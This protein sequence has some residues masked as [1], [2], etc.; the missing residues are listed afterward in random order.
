[1]RWP[2]RPLSSFQC[3]RAEARR[4]GSHIRSALTRQRLKPGQ[5][6]Q[7]VVPRCSVTAENVRLRGDRR[8]RV[9]TA[10]GH[11]HP[12]P[13]LGPWQ[14]RAASGAERPNMPGARDR[15][16]HHPIGPRQPAHAAT[17]REQVGGMC[18]PAALAAATAVTK[19][20]SF[21][22]AMNLELNRSTKAGAVVVCHGSPRLLISAGVIPLGHP[23][24][25]HN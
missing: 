25:D 6:L 21:E 3:H 13:S 20:K 15:E 4:R 7:R 23:G 24:K 12:T 19:E 11:H 2:N 16:L 10:G 22:R 1:M 17:G 18:R 5:S 9:Q 14:W 8:C